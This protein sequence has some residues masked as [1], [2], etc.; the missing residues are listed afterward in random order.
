MCIKYCKF[1]EKCLDDYHNSDKKIDDYYSTGWSD[2]RFLSENKYE[3][4]NPDRFS[5]YDNLRFVQFYL[6][7]KFKYNYY[8][9]MVI[10]WFNNSDEEIITIEGLYPGRNGA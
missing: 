7:E 10:E 8:S 9:R 3:L 1:I 2:F 4:T 6:K 5:H